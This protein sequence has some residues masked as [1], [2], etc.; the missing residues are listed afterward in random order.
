LFL[1]TAFADKIG[2]HDFLL[3]KN[4][5]DEVTKIVKEKKLSGVKG[6]TVNV[7]DIAIAHDG[8]LKHTEEVNLENLRFG[9][10]NLTK[11]TFLERVEFLI[12]KTE[13]ENWKVVNI[14]VE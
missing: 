2:V 10:K 8:F 4:I 6:V 3:A 7:G 11:G 5:I 9:I 14:E 13:G 1:L 12:R